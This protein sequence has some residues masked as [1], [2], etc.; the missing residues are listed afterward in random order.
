M[1]ETLVKYLAGLLDADGSLSF[2]FRVGRNTED[3]SY[4]SLMLSLASS[5]AVDKVGFVESL[6]VI[7]G[8]GVYSLYGADQQFSRWDVAKRAD[9]EML[10]PRLIKHMVI[11]GKHW[12]WM[13]ETWREMRGVLL[14]PQERMELAAR[15]KESRVSR[16]GPL[17]PKN[18]PTWAWLAGY[19]DGDGWYR[20]NTLPNRDCMMMQI[21]AVAH[22]NDV[23]VLHFIQT[24][25]GG[26]VRDHGQTPNCFVWTVGIG[27][28]NRSRALNM[29]PNLTKHARLKKHKIDQMIHH[30]QQRLSDP[31][32][33]G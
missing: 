6:P 20:F 17:K 10:L 12:N 28:K 23:S 19:L 21:G 26:S 16:V 29:L 8:M 1:N 14:T 2:K 24:A 22:M 7:T 25:F 4:P 3:R 18:H 11:K 30:H 27:V 33:T 32:P 15:S 13:L 9:L 5:R 31:S